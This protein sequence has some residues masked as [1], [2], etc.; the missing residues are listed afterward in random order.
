MFEG[1]RG[2]DELLLGFA[3]VVVVWLVMIGLDVR[4]A[5]LVRVTGVVLLVAGAAMVT[6]G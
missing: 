5:T 2:E 1:L 3:A 6:R 4:P